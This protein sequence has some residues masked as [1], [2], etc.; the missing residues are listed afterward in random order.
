VCPPSLKFFPCHLSSLDVRVID[1][2]DFEFTATGGLQC[3]NDVVNFTVV[4][5]YADNSVIRFWNGRFFFDAYDI[6]SIEFGNAKST[7]IRNLLK[8]DLRPSALMA[9]RADRRSD[10]SFNDVVAQND[11]HRISGSKMFYQRECLCDSTFS[12][13]VGVIE[14]FQAKCLAVTEQTKKVTRRTSARH[15]HD[16]VDP[17]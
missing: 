3:S 10:I 16:V 5:V 13:L 8:Y 14:M 7:G 11:A 4:H 15:D 6:L 2:G 12:L 17:G 9:I 1:V